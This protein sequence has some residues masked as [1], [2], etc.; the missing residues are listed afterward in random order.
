M[1]KVEEKI[2]SFQEEL[3]SIVGYL[4]NAPKSALPSAMKDQPQQVQVVPNVSPVMVQGQLS[5][6]LRCKQWEEFQ[7]LATH[8]QTLVFSYK[9]DGKVFEVDAL[10]GNQIIIYM[11][12]LPHFSLI[13]KMWLSR[14][15]E[16]TEQR[17]FEGSL[18]K[19]K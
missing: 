17:I 11:G 13:L 16:I 10:K 1:E 4:S 8:A 14:Q 18:D 2:N 9:E 6:V 19:P 15:F 5:I 7:V 12:A 3:K